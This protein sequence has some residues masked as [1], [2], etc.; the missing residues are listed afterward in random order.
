MST[1]YKA[2][3][4][5]PAKQL[6]NDHEPA[7]MC[8]LYRLRINPRVYVLNLTMIF[9]IAR[10]NPNQFSLINSSSNLFIFT[11]RNDH[12]Q[13]IATWIVVNNLTV[14]IVD[15]TNSKTS[16]HLISR[17]FS[18]CVNVPFGT[19]ANAKLKYFIMTRSSRN[20]MSCCLDMRVLKIHDVIARVANWSKR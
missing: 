7:C 15:A 1:L 3:S 6:T 16:F 17:L 12:W 20:S 4:R 2:S 13:D 10:Q 9:L 5:L 14:R 19:R 11:E 8:H 18:L